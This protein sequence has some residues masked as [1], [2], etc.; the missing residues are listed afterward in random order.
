MPELKKDKILQIINANRQTDNHVDV[1]SVKRWKEP[2]RYSTSDLDGCLAVVIAG[3]EGIVL[4]HYLAKLS[5]HQNDLESLRKEATPLGKNADAFLF[6]QKFLGEYSYKDQASAFAE[7]ISDELGLDVPSTT[8]YGYA[9]DL[10]TMEEIIA[11]DDSKDDID[12]K[13]RGT[14]L[15]D[16]EH[17]TGNLAIY[18]EGVRYPMGRCS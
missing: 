2:G 11:L 15:V 3:R 10:A 5:D 16:Y 6:A 9:K 1:G 17:A 13:L 14:L 7:F 12:V 18:I 4:A 8:P